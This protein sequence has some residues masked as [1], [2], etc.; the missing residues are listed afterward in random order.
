MKQNKFTFQSKNLV[1]D[2]IGFKIQGFVDV[3]PIGKYLF[4]KYGFNSTIRKRIEGKCHSESLNYDS[5]NQFQV[6]FRQ[7]DYD[8]KFN[9]FWEGCVINFSGNNA[10]QIYKI[11]Q[12]KNLDWNIFKDVS[13]SRFDIHYFRKSNS[14][15]SNQQVKNFLESTYTRIRAKSKRRKVS[16]DPNKEPYILKIG[17]R[18]SSNYYRVYQKRK[19]LNH[20]VFIESVEGLE[21][22]LEIKK[23]FLKSF[24]QLLFNNRIDEFEEK[25]TQHFFNQS[26]QNFGLHFSYTDWIRDFYRKLSYTREFNTGLVTDYLR[27]TKFDSLDE[28]K[29]FFRFLQ[30]LSF[31]RKME[32]FRQFIDDQVYYIVEFPVVDFLRFL[33]KNPKSTYQRNKVLTFLKSL[34][35]LPPFIERFSEIEFRSSIMFPLLKLTKKHGSWIIKISV[36]E[37]LYYYSYPFLFSNYFCNFQNKYD[38]LLKLEI[39][40]IFSTDSLEKSFSVEDFMNR[41]SISNQKRMD[42]KKRMVELLNELKTSNSVEPHFKIIYK[43]DAKKKSNEEVTKLTPALLSQSKTIFLHEVVNSNY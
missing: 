29:S 16:F 7:Y 4:Q 6:D 2:W 40:Q 26:R 28:T 37:Q 25:L 12:A 34:Q 43:D 20:S 36:G 42:I 33:G 39:I 18:T 21:F 15:D 9:S 31:L 41:F 13:L 3:K 17:S 8:P 35:D 32:G 11:L 14:V 24:Q 22:E 38:L 23:D 19:N 30:F 5:K 1:V 27:Q 10:A